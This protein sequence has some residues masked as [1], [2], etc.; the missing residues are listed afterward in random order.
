MGLSSNASLAL[1]SQ[2]SVL[3][4]RLEARCRVPQGW[5]PDTKDSELFANYVSLYALCAAGR[6]AT[7]RLK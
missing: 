5:P 1:S 3:A 6:R 2:L 4:M 7:R